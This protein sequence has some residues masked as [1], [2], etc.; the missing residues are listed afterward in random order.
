M[1]FCRHGME[2]A[3]DHQRTGILRDPLLCFVNRGHRL[4]ANGWRNTGIACKCKRSSKIV[5]GSDHG[6]AHLCGQHLPVFCACS[7]NQHLTRPYVW[8]TLDGATGLGQYWSG[9]QD[10]SKHC[11]PVT[12]TLGGAQRHGRAINRSPVSRLEICHPADLR[13]SVRRAKRVSVR[14]LGGCGFL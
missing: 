11:G 8:K 2:N 10:S 6:H 13:R 3:F 4:H 5:S 12:S 14:R 7:R 9:F 1:G